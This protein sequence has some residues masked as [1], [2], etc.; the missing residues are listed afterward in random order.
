MNSAQDLTTQI[1][2]LKQQVES[3]L[4]MDPLRFF[5]DVMPHMRFR[6]GYLSTKYSE[7]DVTS[8]KATI[9]SVNGLRAE[10]DRVEQKLREKRHEIDTKRPPKLFGKSKYEQDINTM[11]QHIQSLTDDMAGISSK[12]N[13]KTSDYDEATRLLSEHETEQ[14][15]HARTYEADEKEFEEVKSSAL[16]AIAA[17]LLDI[18]GIQLADEWTEIP[19]SVKGFFRADPTRKLFPIIGWQYAYPIA[20]KMFIQEDSW[21]EGG[22]NII[23]DGKAVLL[24]DAIEEF[25]WEYCNCDET[26]DDNSFFLLVKA[27]ACIRMLYKD[28]DA[29]FIHYLHSNVG[30]EQA[31][32]A[33][34]TLAKDTTKSFA[35]MFKKCFESLDAAYDLSLRDGNESALN[36]AAALRENIDNNFGYFRTVVGLRKS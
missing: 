1:D 2:S 22:G 7:R 15:S 13:T 6:T 27:F 16:S 18:P 32:T 17:S 3:A 20:L 35:K 25:L 36:A 31:I 28:E 10:K 24:K 12:I 19:E 9:A 11:K 34:G 26:R 4:T 33:A 8:A 14:A 23:V 21:G 5:L 30:K 29:N